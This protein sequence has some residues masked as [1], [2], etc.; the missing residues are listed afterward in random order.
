MDGTTKMS[1]YAS[2]ELKDVQTVK[3]LICYLLYR[4]HKPIDSEQLYD[5]AVSTD[6]INYFFYQDAID[7]L[8]KNNSI[9]V[10]EGENNSKIFTLTEKGISCAKTLRGYVPKSY[11]DKIVTA[12]LRYF[13][14][15]KYESE[16]KIEYIKLE[17]GYYV[18]CRC[19]DIKDDLMD[20]K[21][22]APD[23]GQA[24]LLGKNIM[25]NPTGFYSKVLDIALNNQEEEFD[26][27]DL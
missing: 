8:I 25:K 20:L 6:I 19:L 13:A 17:K 14:K 4:I 26:P 5:I 21:L 2:T 7:Y 22:Y 18:H 1:E 15:Q 9:D 27:E 16:V 12:A 23:L 11:R 10:S 24:E 3:I